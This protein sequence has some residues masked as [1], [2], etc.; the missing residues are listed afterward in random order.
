MDETNRPR[1]IAES[2]GC[3]GGIE[4]QQQR[5][6]IASKGPGLERQK[7]RHEHAFDLVHG[8]AHPVVAVSEVLERSGWAQTWTGSGKMRDGCFETAELGLR[9]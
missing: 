3:P 4:A 8:L 5:T 6:R 2:V 9:G 7:R 1:Q